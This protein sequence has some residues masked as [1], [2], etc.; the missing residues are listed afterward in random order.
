MVM[1]NTKKKYF[2]GLGNDGRANT[3]FRVGCLKRKL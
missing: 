2:T 3:V 1:N